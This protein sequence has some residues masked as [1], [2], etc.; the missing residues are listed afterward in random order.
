MRDR[1]FA[2]YV[3]GTLARDLSELADLRRV[4]DAERL[5]RLLA[6]QSANLLSYRAVGSRLDMHHDTVKPTLHFWSR[7]AWSGACRLGARG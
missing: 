6:T 3:A 2:I 7:W 5:L 4:D 1:W